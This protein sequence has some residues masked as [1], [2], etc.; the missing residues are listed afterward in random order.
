MER[1]RMEKK[2]SKEEGVPLTEKSQKSKL[3]EFACN[4]EPVIYTIFTRPSSSGRQI[5]VT[6]DHKKSVPVT[7]KFLDLCFSF[8]FSNKW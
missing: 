8:S 7:I 1:E 6:R 4:F 2:R 3:Q 5:F